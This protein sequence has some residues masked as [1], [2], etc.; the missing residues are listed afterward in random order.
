MLTLGGICVLVSMRMRGSMEF[1]HRAL[2]VPDFAPARSSNGHDQSQA[3]IAEACS[4]PT[5]F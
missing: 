1:G 5:P 3:V 2:Q 4:C